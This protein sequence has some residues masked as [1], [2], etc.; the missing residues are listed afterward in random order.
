MLRLLGLHRQHDPVRPRDTRYAV[1]DH[2][3]HR[4]PEQYPPDCARVGLGLDC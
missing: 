3:T 1:S 2:P 4:L